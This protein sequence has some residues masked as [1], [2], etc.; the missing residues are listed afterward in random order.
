VLPEISVE[1]LHKKSDDLLVELSSQLLG[2]TNQIN[3]LCALNEADPA[4][5][6][7]DGTPEG[8]STECIL[9]DCEDNQVI[10]D[11][12]ADFLAKILQFA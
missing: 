11:K 10:G 5:A 2:V 7:G 4:A 12:P 1:E 6:F 9:A 3:I 8:P